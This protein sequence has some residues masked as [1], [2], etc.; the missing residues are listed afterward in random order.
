MRIGD[1]GEF[2]LIEH[3][4]RIAGRSRPDVVV[5]IGDDTAALDLGGRTSSSSL[6]TARSRGPTSSAIVRGLSLD[7]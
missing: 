5:E 2:P 6:W 4:A 3:L 7:L 1:V